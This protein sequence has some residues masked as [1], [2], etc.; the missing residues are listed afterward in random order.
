MGIPEEKQGK[1]DSKVVNYIT[2]LFLAA[3]TLLLMTY[4]MEQREATE[5]LDGLRHSVSAM[6]SVD[7]LYLENTQLQDEVK[8]LE[9]EKFL[10]E[11]Q[12]QRNE[13]SIADLEEAVLS[14]EITA[15]AMDWF[16]Q[17]N[18]AFVLERWSLARS[19]IE[20]MESQE[21]QGYLPLES[22]TDNMRFSP[23]HRYL[24]IKRDL[25]T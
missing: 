2:I 6:Q 25:E 10:L 16:W 20:E 15:R 8:E 11:Q 17:V 1:K 3:F 21:L 18:E 13:D 5:T 23:A 12:R 14:G 19:L 4:M 24:E 9:Q 22:D 7:E